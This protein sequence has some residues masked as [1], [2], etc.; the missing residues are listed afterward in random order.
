MAKDIENER[1]KKARLMERAR[2]LSDADLAAI[3]GERAAAAAAKAKAKAA[4]KGKA[5]AKAKAKA[6]PA[7]APPVGGDEDGEEA[8]IEEDLA[9]EAGLL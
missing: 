1:R 9:E 5:K 7:A 3:I 4:A 2:G 6:A 8:A